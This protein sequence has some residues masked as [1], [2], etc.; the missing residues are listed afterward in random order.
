MVRN[1]PDISL[2]DLKKQFPDEKYNSIK[3]YRLQAL[4]DISKVIPKKRKKKQKSIPPQ[5]TPSTAE[6]AHTIESIENPV[7]YASAH[8]FKKMVETGD[9]R[10]AQ[11]YVSL[12]DKTKK[13]DYET[14]REQEWLKQAANMSMDELVSK[15]AV[16]G[17]TSKNILRR[18]E[19]TEDTS[20]YDN[21]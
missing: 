1:D 21:F 2:K 13:L 20:I 8:I 17:F 15:V 11:L 10:W 3:T 16:K 7:A 18:L 9:V 5:N 6:I 4:K 14:I 12:L 19:E